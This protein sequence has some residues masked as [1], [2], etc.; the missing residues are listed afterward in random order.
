MFRFTIRELVLVTAVA[1]LGCGWWMTE[2][3]RRRERLENEELRRLQSAMVR[4]LR[5]G[6]DLTVVYRPGSLVVEAS[7]GRYSTSGW[8]QAANP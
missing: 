6:W 1:A 7:D 3:Q 5:A 2:S 4:V 8:Q